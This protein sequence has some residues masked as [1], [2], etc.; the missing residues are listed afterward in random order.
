MRRRG[1]LPSGIFN[2]GNSRNGK[3]T[4][5]FCCMMVE[6]VAQSI[7]IMTQCE[8]AAFLSHCL[9]KLEK[10]AGLENAAITTF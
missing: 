2:V 7:K 5:H 4:T 8:T 9:G 3:R 1:R 6:I 10:M